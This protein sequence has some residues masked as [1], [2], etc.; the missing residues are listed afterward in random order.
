QPIDGARRSGPAPA[1]GSAEGIEVTR[2]A[3]DLSPSLRQ[4]GVG[5]VEVALQSLDVFLPCFERLLQLFDASVT[6]CAPDPHVNWI[7]TLQRVLI[8]DERRTFGDMFVL[9]VPAQCLLLFGEARLP[10]NK[11]LSFAVF[12]A[13]N[14]V[15]TENEP[16]RED[17]ASVEPCV[18]SA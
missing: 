4:R 15:M 3:R 17:L 14:R 8:V 12:L 13:A 9:H 2:Q 10:L 5:A 6:Q 7:E 11:H 18:V 16:H 1:E